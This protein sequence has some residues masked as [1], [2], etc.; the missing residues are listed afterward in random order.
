LWHAHLCFCRWV[1]PPASLIPWEMVAV[2]GSE[3]SPLLDFLRNFG[4]L[5]VFIADL[6]TYLLEEG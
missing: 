3:L 6:V 4:C 2:K 5:P 1:I